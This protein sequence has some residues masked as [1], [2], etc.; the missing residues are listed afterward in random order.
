MALLPFISCKYINCACVAQDNSSL[1]H[2][3]QAATRLD[4]HGSEHQWS[5]EE[6]PE[7]H[8]TTHKP[9]S[10]PLIPSLYSSTNFSSTALFPHPNLARPAMAPEPPGSLS[11]LS[12]QMTNSPCTSKSRCY[13]QTSKNVTSAHR[14]Y[15][16][17]LPLPKR[18]T[19]S[20]HLDAERPSFPDPR[21]G[22]S[23]CR[24]LQMPTA[25]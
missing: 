1:L 13:L 17:L 2:A 9:H 7:A 10:T 25:I 24:K 3:A 15:T 4:T 16:Q 11:F 22:N 18:G 19:P 5:S 6:V 14:E 12:A 20:S 8:C 23:F 21:K